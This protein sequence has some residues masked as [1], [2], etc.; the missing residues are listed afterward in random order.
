MDLNYLLHRHQVSLMQ[1]STAESPEARS[2]HRGL[3]RA[4]AAGIRTLQLELGASA[5]APQVA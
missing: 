2:S 3:V 1:A 5:P 4:Y